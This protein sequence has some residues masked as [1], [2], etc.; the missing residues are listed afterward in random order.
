MYKEVVYETTQFVER[1]LY[2]KIGAFYSSLDAD[3]ETETGE[4]EEGIYYVWKESE[5]KQILKNDFE[6]FSN[7]YN[8]NS[9][10]KWENNS[11]HLIRNMSDN[12]FISKFGI[13]EVELKK[14]VKIWKNNLS[15]IRNERPAPRLDDKTLTSWNALMLK[16]YADAYSVFDDEHFLNMALKNAHFIINKQMKEDGGLYRN[17]KNEISNIEAY[18]EDYGTVVDA[19]IRLYEVTLDE[20]WLQSAKQLTDYTFDHFYDNKSKMFFFTSDKAKDLITRK[21]EIDDNVIPSSNSI[22]ANNLFKLGHYYSNKKYSDNAKSMLNNIKDNVVKY[23]AGASNWLNL[24][25]NY[26]GDFYE[27]AISGNKAKEKLI[28]INQTYI[29]N[30]IIVGSS[31]ESNLP[32]LEYKYSKNETTIFVCVDGACQLPVSESREALDQIKV[33]F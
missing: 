12:E 5:L 32:L 31:K 21:I 33:E 14:K 13:S 10:G 19:F 24:Y 27:I 6:L 17:Y 25:S 15:E 11:Y 3:S 22:M 26:L 29:P 7:Y 18:L 20:N 23:G 30:K 4:L 28:E 2:N 1:E 8:V 9:Y 16:D